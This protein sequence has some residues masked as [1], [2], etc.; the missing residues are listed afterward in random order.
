MRYPVSF[1]ERIETLPVEII[2]DFRKFRKSSAIPAELQNYIL[3]LESVIQIRDQEKCDNISEISRQL[4]KKYPHLE[5][6]TCRQRVYDALSFFHIDDNIAGKIWDNIYADKME[7][8]AK[9]LIAKGN[10]AAAIKAYALAHDYRTKAV[11]RIKPEDLKPPVF[12]I[13]TKI[14]PEDLG[15]ERKNLYDIARKAAQ[16]KYVDM[17]EGLP[18]VNDEEKKRLKRDAG[19]DIEDAK[20]IDEDE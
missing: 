10:E 15:Y 2:A 17:I 1:L 14:K 13:I 6:R 19:L 18:G 4:Q 12:L 20:I 11:N 8:I 3:E 9:L 5:F 16:G 7:D